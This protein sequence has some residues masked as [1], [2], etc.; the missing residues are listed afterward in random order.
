MQ[1]ISGTY[2]K[3]KL[4][5]GVLLLALA[6][7]AFS[8]MP[9]QSNQVISMRPGQTTS[10]QVNPSHSPQ[11]LAGQ[12]DIPTDRII[13]KYKSSTS[14]FAAPAGSAQM[15]RLVTAGGISLHYLR[16][17]SGNANVLSLPGRLPLVQVQAISRSLMGLPEVEYAVPD[18]FRFPT[19][20][21]ND[22]LYTNQWDL[23]ESNGINAPAAWDITT[24]ASS[25]VVADIDTGILNH[26]DLSG[27][28]V[29]GYDFIS[30]TLVSNDG[31]GRDADP[32]DPG[33]WVAKNECYPGSSASNSSWHGT[34]TAGT[35][36]ASGNNSLGVAGINWNSK[37]LPVRVLG[38]C[39]GYDSDIIDGMNWAAGLPVSGVPANP[40]PAKVLNLSL[41][42][43]GT[44]ST[45]WQ[46][47]VNT[48]TSAGAVVVVAAGNS[49]ADASN[50]TPASCNGVITV[51][52]TNRSGSRAYYSNYGSNVEISAPGGAQSAA[53]D[54]NGI[55]STLN[56]GTTVPASDTYIY[57]QGTSMATP[58]VTGV[59]SLM[60]SLNP[61]LTPTQVLQIVQSTARPFPAGS[62]CTTALCGSGMLDAGAAVNAVPVTI[63]GFS[64]TSGAIGTSVTI[65]G[66]NFS[67][68]SAVKFNGANASFTILTATSIT[69]SVPAGATTGPIS[70]TN[71][72]G[73]ITSAASFTVTGPSATPSMT[74]TPS[75]TPSPTLTSTPTHTFT[76][77]NTPT[78]TFTPTITPSPTPTNTPTSTPS[79]TPTNTNT[80]TSTPSRTP[81]FTDT[82]TPTFTPTHTSTLTSTFTPSPT[83]TFTNTFTATP[84]STPSSTNTFTTTPSHTSTF[85]NTPTPTFT[86]SPTSTPTSTSTPTPTFTPTGTF[87]PTSTYTSSPSSTLTS[88]YTPTL[89][90]TPTH[91]F[92]PTSTDTPTL[93]PGFSSTPT[94]TFTQ[95]PTFTPSGT[96][97][98]TLT[99]S[100]TFTLIPTFTFTLTP[101]PTSTITPSGQIYSIFLPLFMF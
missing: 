90:F 6:T 23:Y 73:T 27:R 13:V 38:K 55:L 52:A 98:L 51:A 42:G 101:T 83:P 45:A 7:S 96:P 74:N 12:A 70:L 81:T 71:P 91:T 20:T 46:N 19:L 57:Y 61:F 92:T 62:T 82:P 1:R 63:S 30:D 64:P 94:L 44:C 2:N 14:A 97:T 85:T 39:G 79:N 100:G 54:P 16:K 60:F 93:T 36:G 58:H 99:P 77:T 32:G 17:M 86:P 65:S 10:S 67:H 21:P 9:V 28:T 87:T 4:I 33:D 59:V 5:V 47:A 18:Q 11:Q 8:N 25:I 26:A 75:T 69:A 95:T 41:G 40:N 24:G 37:I 34:H 89:T 78:S 50:F 72:S 53:N 88:T 48:V 80:S 15:A 68:V 35:I 29:A 56:T 49:N 76:P 22:S 66:A 31:N 3:N 43:S 84:S